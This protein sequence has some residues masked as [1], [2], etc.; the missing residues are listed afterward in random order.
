MLTLQGLGGVYDEIFLPLHGAHQAQNAAVALAAVEAFLG[1]G[2]G[3]AARRRAWSARASRRRRSPGRLERVRTRADDPA[4]R[5]AQP[6]RHGR[7]GRRAAGGVRVPPPGRRGGGA[8]PTRTRPGCSTCSSRSSTW[9]WCTR[10]TSPRVRC[11]SRELAP[12]AVEIFGAGPGHVGAD[13]PDAIETAVA[14][15]ESDVEAELS[16]VGVLI[17]GS[18]V[19]VADA[20]KLLD[21]ERDRDRRRGRRARVRR[22]CAT[23]RRRY[24][25]S[26]RPRSPSRRSSCCS[27][28]S[29]SACSAARW[30]AGP[31]PPWWRSPSPPPCW[32]A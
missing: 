24:A 16:G 22:A 18:I 28:S 13:M 15:A 11:R 5:R 9:S 3:P 27:R 21:D 30:A 8:R 10:N 7:H 17:T 31:W 29:R 14:L 4:R 2:A 19:T 25:D 12:L 6:A 20:R 1:A 32:P 26:A 23:R